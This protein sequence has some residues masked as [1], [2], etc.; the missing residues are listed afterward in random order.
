MGFL[1]HGSHYHQNKVIKELNLTGIY[2]P[3]QINLVTDKNFEK[4]MKQNDY[5]N[6]EGDNRFVNKDGA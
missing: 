2:A 3:D 6:L 1:C 4:Y 5:N